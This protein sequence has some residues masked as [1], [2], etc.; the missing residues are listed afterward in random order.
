MARQGPAPLAIMTS[1]SPA[2]HAGCAVTLDQGRIVVQETVVAQ[3]CIEIATIG[4]PLISMQST[5]IAVPSIHV[6]FRPA[7]TRNSL[8]INYSLAGSFPASAD[9]WAATI[10][11]SRVGSRRNVT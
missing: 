1:A 7:L 2:C 6:G 5:G 10:I 8:K 11:L 9:V 3:G 4:I